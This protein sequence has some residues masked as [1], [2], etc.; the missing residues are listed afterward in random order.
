M[1]V[2]H[3]INLDSDFPFTVIVTPIAR[4]VWMLFKCF[5]EIKNC[6]EFNYFGLWGQTEAQCISHSKRI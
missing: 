2:L 5:A 4:L 3:N 1:R 6:A